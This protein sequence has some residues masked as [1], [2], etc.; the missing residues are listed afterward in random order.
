MNNYII[1]KFTFSDGKTY[2]G[3]TS[4]PIEERW[5][6]GDGYKGQDVYVPIILEGWDNIKKE[7]LHTNLTHEQ[8]NELEKHYIK[9]FNS[10]KN[11]YNR[12]NG[13]SGIKTATNI[14]E[15]EKELQKLTEEL[16]KICPALIAPK[17]NKLLTLQEIRALAK[18]NPN[19]E[20]I[21]EST[22]LGCNYSSIEKI[23]DTVEVR[24]GGIMDCSLWDFLVHWRV[25]EDNPNIKTILNTP[26]LKTE[27][28]LEYTGHFIID[29]KVKKF[30]LKNHNFPSIQ[31]A[32]FQNY[33]DRKYGGS[34][35]NQKT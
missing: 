13:G 6:S 4:L 11:G 23:N 9:K 32:G 19:K 17:P 31:D 24:A 3:Q 2:I 14:E 20:I 16:I 18:T 35:A 8:A 26:W 7:V 30:F 15:E 22:Y 28:I 12:T 34:A 33:F 10:I 21:Y 25:W 5:K 29:K 27:Q 1:Y